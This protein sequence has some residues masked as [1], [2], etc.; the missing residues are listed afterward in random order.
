MQQQS[1]DIL[2]WIWLSRRLGAGSRLYPALLERFGTPGQ[3]SRR[4]AQAVFA[5][6][7]GSLISSWIKQDPEDL[8]MARESLR[9]VFKEN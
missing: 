9:D 3:E 6:I 7:H 5:L 8:V 2:F 1:N 4:R